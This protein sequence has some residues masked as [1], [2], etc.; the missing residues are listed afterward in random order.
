MDFR[1]FFKTIPGSCPDLKY[2]VNPVPPHTYSRITII[3]TCLEKKFNLK[4]FFGFRSN[5][6][7]LKANDDLVY[8][9]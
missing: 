6:L 4:T 1:S 3:L 5:F 9:L 8:V 7:M 2:F